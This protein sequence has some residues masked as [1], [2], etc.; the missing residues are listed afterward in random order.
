MGARRMGKFII[1]SHDD[2]Y[3]FRLLAAN[4]ESVAVSD[5]YTSLSACLRGIESVRR[6]A[7]A[8]LEDQT[9]RGYSSLPNPKYELYKDRKR[10]YRYRLR[11]RNGKIIATGGGHSDKDLCIKGIESVRRNAAKARII[12]QTGK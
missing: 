4:Q 10:Q 6:N 9:V 7:A 5:V 2:G 12:D 3:D 1:Q 11:A 8:R